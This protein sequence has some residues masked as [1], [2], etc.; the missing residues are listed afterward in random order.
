VTLKTGRLVESGRENG[1]IAVLLAHIVATL[2]H[3]MVVTDNAMDYPPD[4]NSEHP[5]RAIVG[6]QE[7]GRTVCVHSLGV[8]PSFQ[9]L[10]LGRILMTA[11]I[12]QISGA[13]IANRIAIVAHEVRFHNQSLLDHWLNPIAP[14]RLL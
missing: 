13:G 1:A 4:W 6:H 2:S 12:Q 9:G 11:Y 7:G 10:G 8:L 5:A 14:G 3:D